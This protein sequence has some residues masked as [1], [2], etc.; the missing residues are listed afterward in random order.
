MAGQGFFFA[1][2]ALIGKFKALV[3]AIKAFADLLQR[4]CRKGTWQPFGF[5]F[6]KPFE[7]MFLQLQ[8]IVI[9]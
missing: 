4:R 2:E 8:E 5:S 9:G 7:K 3:H 6:S 1:N